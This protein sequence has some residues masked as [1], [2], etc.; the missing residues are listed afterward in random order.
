MR[1][2]RAELERRERR[3]VYLFKEGK[4]D[5]AEF[6]RELTRIRNRLLIVA[7][8]DLQRVELSLAEFKCFKENWGHATPEEKYDI[9]TSIMDR[10]YADFGSGSIVELVLKDGFRWIL[11]ASGTIKPPKEDLGDFRL[12]IGDPEGIRTPDLHRDRVAC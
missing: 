12:V 11:E 1:N 3:F 8:G 7:P 2:E 5:Q 9:L 6:D 4:I 10:A